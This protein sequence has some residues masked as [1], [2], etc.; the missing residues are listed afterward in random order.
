[1]KAFFKFIYKYAE[2]KGIFFT[3]IITIMLIII[4][5]YNLLK[6]RIPIAIIIIIIEPI[7]S[8]IINYYKLSLEAKVLL[9]ALISFPLLILLFK[10]E[11]FLEELL[12]VSSCT[13]FYIIFSLAYYELRG[14]KRIS[15]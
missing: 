4:Y 6:I 12:T 11:D 14:K 15:K 3:L 7:R 10:E 2:R 1:M 5:K 13:I 9:N 8:A